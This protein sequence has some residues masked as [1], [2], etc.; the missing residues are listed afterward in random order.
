MYLVTGGLG[1]SSGP[2]DYLTSTEILLEGGASWSIVGDLPR[3]SIGI[4]CVSFDNKIILTG[5]HYPTDRNLALDEFISVIGGEYN[6]KTESDQVLL[7]NTNEEKWENVG[8]L[9]TVRYR[10]GMSTIPLADVPPSCYK[11]GK[12]F[13]TAS[14]RL[15][16]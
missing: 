11:S 15:D 7:F 16:D 12:I 14:E 8:K 9:K 3:A 4:R 5:N 1:A 13:L 2:E 6:D 10:H